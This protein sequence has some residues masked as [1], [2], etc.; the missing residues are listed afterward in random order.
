MNGLAQAQRINV[1]NLHPNWKRL[2]LSHIRQLRMMLHEGRYTTDCIRII[3]QKQ[4]DLL[5]VRAI[6]AKATA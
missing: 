3:K 6:L 1:A 5:S 2:A 4:R